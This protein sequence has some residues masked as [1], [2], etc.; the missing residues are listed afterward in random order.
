MTDASESERE[1]YV[2]IQSNWG[3]FSSDDLRE[4]LSLDDRMDCEPVIDNYQHNYNGEATNREM[5]NLVQSNV[6]TAPLSD[7]MLNLPPQEQTDMVIEPP[8]DVTVAPPP[9]L[10]P[11]ANEQTETPNNSEQKQPPLPQQPRRVKIN[12]W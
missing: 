6:M 3:E 1:G 12:Q 8:N 4:F 9:Q 10:P 5:P 11:P 7:T 2:N